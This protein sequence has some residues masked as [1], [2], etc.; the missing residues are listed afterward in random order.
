V[1]TASAIHLSTRSTGCTS[2]KKAA[3][4]QEKR[5]LHL[6][7]CGGNCSNQD[8]P[9]SSK[10]A[11]TQAAHGPGSSST[12]SHVAA[13][14]SSAG[15]ISRRGKLNPDMP[16]GKH[17]RSAHTNTLQHARG[18]HNGADWSGEQL[19]KP[20]QE[21]KAELI[22]QRMG[23]PTTW[24]ELGWSLGTSSFCPH[25]CCHGCGA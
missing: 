24:L 11:A 5:T 19:A 12:T 14:D 6:A 16:A 21:C 18:S 2:Q 10:H 15:D 4:P 8:D 7:C 23:A 20:Q 13:G 9:S 1:L 3:C 25:Q 17:N 22:S